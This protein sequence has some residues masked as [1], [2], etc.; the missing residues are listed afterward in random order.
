[1]CASFP[2]WYHY[3]RP[4]LRHLQPLT[5]VFLD[6]PCTKRKK[7]R[8]ASDFQKLLQRMGQ[9][10]PE[11]TPH[12]HALMLIHP[13]L[14]ERFEQKQAGFETLF[15]SLSPVNRT[16][17][18]RELTKPGDDERVLRYSSE[19]LAKPQHPDLRDVDLFMWLPKAR[20]EPTYQKV[21]I[22]TR[23]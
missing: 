21:T 5:F 3:D 22:R 23:A 11:M 4:R 10:Y 15:K 17:D 19:L 14:V 12:I 9:E 13:D 8:A 1:M 18:I 7:N 16:L 6:F 20:S 2:S